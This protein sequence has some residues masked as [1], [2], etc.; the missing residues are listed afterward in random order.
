MRNVAG[1]SEVWILVD[2]AW[3]ETRNVGTL[4]ID[5]RERVGKGRGS[6]DWRE[7]E[8][9]DVV[10]LIK[11]KDTFDLVKVDVFLHSD[12]VGIK[13]FDVFN[14]AKD[15]GLLWVETKSDDI[16]NVA[17]TH[18]NCAFWSFEL[19]LWAVDVLLIICDLDHNGYIEGLLQI[20]AH[21]ERNGVTEVKR[22]S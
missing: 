2:G 5:V 14:V 15:K 10:R 4:A 3:N 17:Q 12:D 11:A 22:L 9:S 16:F 21:N 20:L 13:F 8:L 19:K 1:H 18:C 7:G 6:L